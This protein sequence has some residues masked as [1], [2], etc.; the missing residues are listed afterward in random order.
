MN[1]NILSIDPMN[2]NS[3][4]G[5]RVEIY[6]SEDAELTMTPL[7]TVNRIRKFRPYFGPDGG[8][9]TFKGKDIFK[10]A[11][12]LKE[13]CL[14]CHKAGINTCIETDGLEYNN[15][16]ELLNYTDLFIINI[17]SLPLYN[18]NDLTIEQ[19]MNIDKLMNH[20]NEKNINIWIKQAIQKD[21]NDS[22][23]YFEILKKYLGRYDN[24]K[25]I[26]IIGN[27]ISNDKLNSFQR[28][29]KEV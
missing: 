8:G 18:Y 1:G 25:D 21:I 12:Y 6:L 14:I 4:P 27:D 11:D 16:L 9:V 29:L 20:L 2:L 5:I 17:I 28:I 24:I 22:C 10:Y 23:E 13:T 3:G 15:N 19:L 26:E 7:E